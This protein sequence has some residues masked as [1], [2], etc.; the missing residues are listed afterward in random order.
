MLNLSAALAGHYWT[1]LPFLADRLRSE[2]RRPAPLRAEPWSLDIPDARFG[3]VRLSGRLYAPEGAE[4]ALL[5]IHG[6]GGNAESGYLRSAVLDAYA[7]GVTCLCLNLRGADGLG[8]DLY[9]AALTSDLHAALGSDSLAGY[10][11]L[12]VLGFSLG[13][14]LALR[15]ATEPHAARLRSVA[16]V[17]APLDL[18]RCQAALP[19]GQL[20]SHGAAAPGSDSARA[21][22]A[23]E[24]HPGVG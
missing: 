4:R 8:E 24:Q 14:H 9:H 1:L 15:L 6:L 23:R 5:L 17:C 7:A 16:A 11:S 12:H 18:Q 22:A 19:E 13:G 21:G 20:R 2:G 3:S 10:R